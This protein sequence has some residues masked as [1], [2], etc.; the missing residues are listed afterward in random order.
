MT[1]KLRGVQPEEIKKRLKV[2][3]YGAAKIGKTTA[4]LHFPRP[5][6]ID[7]EG[8]AD[9][10]MYSKLIKDNEG[11]VYQTQDFDEVIATVKELLT[12][13]HDYK[14]LIIDSFTNLYNDL[15]DREELRV[16]NEFGRHYLAANK[17]VKHLLNLLLRLDMNVLITCHSKNEY[18]PGMTVIGQTFD[19]FKKLDYLFDIIFE[20]K[21]KGKER[22]A[23]VKGSRFECFKE[24]EVLPFTYEEI[25]KRFGKDVIEQKS[26][27]VKLA[28]FEQ[29]VKLMEL[30]D[31]V[32][33][34]QEIVDKWLKKANAETLEDMPYDSIQA[35]I[36]LLKTKLQG[37]L[38]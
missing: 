12:L 15:V 7:T 37:A 13:E 19:G 9:K 11:L 5:Y 36:D 25:A 38:A 23:H 28:E 33:T 29:V 31:A 2:F 30:I 21:K 16:G 4:C 1:K 17:K 27:P 26:V 20:V 32:K 6:W 3:F 34:P 8:C 35:C 22:I 18:G 24:D 10:P 14:T